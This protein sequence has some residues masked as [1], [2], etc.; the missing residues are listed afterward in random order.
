MAMI[1]K[2]CG[3]TSPH[4]DR[5]MPLAIVLIIVVML[6]DRGADPTIALCS[7][8]GLIAAVGRVTRG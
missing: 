7:V 8:A 1:E 5:S 6:V 3:H 2:T 4:H